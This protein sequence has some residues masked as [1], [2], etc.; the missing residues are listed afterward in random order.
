[1]IKVSFGNK[2]LNL[3]IYFENDF[4]CINWNNKR[5]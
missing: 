3:F 2:Q 1:M 4:L 5:Y